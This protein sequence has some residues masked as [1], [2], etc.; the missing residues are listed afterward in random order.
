MKK[1]VLW[2]F[3]FEITLTV[4]VFGGGGRQSGVSAA[5]QKT[6]SFALWDEV[7]YPVFEEIC[8]RFTQETGIEVDLQLTPWSQYWT[9]LDAAA[10]AGNAADVFWMNI[11]LPKYADA[12]VIEPVEPYF[13]Q[14]GL[15]KASWSPAMI[16]LYTYKNQ[17]YT[18]PKGMDVVVVAYNKAIFDKYGVSYPAEGW[19]WQDMERIGGQLR[20]KIQAAGGSEYPL[21]MELD[22]QPSYLQFWL[23]DG[24]VP[25]SATGTSS[26]FS[27][28][29]ARKAFDDILRLMDQRILP[30]FTILSD[31]KG[32]DLFISSRGAM[33]YVG[34]WKSS[35]L[36]SASFASNIGLI[37]MPSRGVSN[38]CALGGISYALNSRA[39]DK[40]SA[41]QL[42]KFLGGELSN[43]LQAEGRIE[44][45]AYI[46]AQPSYIP[47][48]K[49]IDPSA[50][51][52]QSAAST[53]FPSHPR[54]YDWDGV[55]TEL[56]TE[57][58][59]RTKTPDQALRELATE[60]DALM[61]Q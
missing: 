25:Y 34:S 35:V 45:P 1:I 7:Q 53:V 41:W 21:L 49:N 55:Q 54:M 50:F 47:S 6:V 61:K 37:P 59:N 44:I 60:V 23:Q 43:R 11:F 29:E 31:T 39:A 4:S 40:E 38:V 57:I 36:D 2:A 10:T 17:L 12:G 20:D 13:I 14:D 9:K 18:M 42:I 32:T 22:P 56:V 52:K 15:N 51:I 16:N 8:K 48:F 3:L 19:T 5:G 30:N 26:G 28:S 24:V 46:S 33:L 27:R 58:F